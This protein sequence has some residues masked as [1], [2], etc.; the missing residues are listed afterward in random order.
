[1]S[2]FKFGT[3]IQFASFNFIPPLEIVMKFLPGI[4][5]IFVRFGPPYVLKVHILLDPLNFRPPPTKIKWGQKITAKLQIPAKLVR[6]YDIH[7]FYKM[8]DD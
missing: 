6:V 5:K 2:P 7:V 4:F 3:L 8:A 1:M